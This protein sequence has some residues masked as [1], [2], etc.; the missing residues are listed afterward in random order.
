LEVNTRSRPFIRLAILMVAS[1][2]GVGCSRGPDVKTLDSSNAHPTPG[3]GSASNHC[4][5][6]RSGL[7][8]TFSLQSRSTRCTWTNSQFSHMGR[9]EVFDVELRFDSRPTEGTDWENEITIRPSGLPPVWGN[10]NC[11]G[12]GAG[13]NAYVMLL[14]LYVNKNTSPDRWQLDIRGGKSPHLKDTMGP[15]RGTSI[16]PLVLGP[17]VQGQTLKLKFDIIEDYQRGA[18]TVWVNDNPTPIYNNRDRPLGWHYDCDYT[19]DLSN[20][21]IQVQHGV[22]RGGGGVATLSSSGFRFLTSEP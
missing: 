7:G 17:V 1:A 18:A 22:Y 21:D 6:S 15:G 12:D 16:P 20:F 14:N 2:A 4:T 13:G 3:L 8:D 9:H 10:A 11:A 19:T 5:L